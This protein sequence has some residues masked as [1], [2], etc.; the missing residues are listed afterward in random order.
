[1]AHL[2]LIVPEESSHENKGTLSGIILFKRLLKIFAV[3]PASSE[4][5][6]GKHF[7]DILSS[8]I[9]NYLIYQT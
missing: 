3:R 9:T 4:L 6:S 8:C 5:A 1:M 2:S 7:S